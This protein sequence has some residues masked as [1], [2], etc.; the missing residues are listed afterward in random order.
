MVITKWLLP[1][2]WQRW[3]SHHWIRHTRKPHDT[4]NAAIFCRTGV[5]D[6]R[7]LYSGNMNFPPFCSCDL[8]LT[9]WSSYT[10]F[11]RTPWTYTGC[12]NMNFLYVKAFESYRLA[13]KQTNYA[14]PFPV[15][16]QRCQVHTVKSALPVNGMLH[17]D[18]H[19]RK[20]DLF[21]FL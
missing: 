9:R 3:R 12:A 2:K 10:N 11:T 16:W 13:D 4:R 14:W 7:S 20:P 17:G 19:S 8:D 21:I 15:T 18:T 6:D 5:M 1:V